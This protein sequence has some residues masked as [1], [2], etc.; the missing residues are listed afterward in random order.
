MSKAPPG[1]VSENERR[2][3]RCKRA[4][5][6]FNALLTPERKCVCAVVCIRVHLYSQFSACRVRTGAPRYRPTGP[7]H[8][9]LR[10]P[11][12]DSSL[13]Q[14]RAKDQRAKHR[15]GGDVMNIIKKDRP[16]DHM[17]IIIPKPHDN[18]VQLEEGLN[19]M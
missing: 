8:Q 4:Y 19:L 13:L 1:H 10:P 7:G 18:F 11:D 6:A 2:G 9:T 5:K 16:I 17:K 12:G 14:S 15:Y 3:L